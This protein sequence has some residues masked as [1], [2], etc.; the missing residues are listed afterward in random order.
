MLTDVLAVGDSCGAWTNWT[1]KMA[2]STKPAGKDSAKVIISSWRDSKPEHAATER[3][4]FTTADTLTLY[5]F[6]DSRS[7]FFMGDDLTVGWVLG[8]NPAARSTAEVVEEV[9]AEDS[10]PDSKWCRRRECLR[11]SMRL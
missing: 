6:F 2:S 3:S 8:W 9:E 7:F 4:H 10:L 5:C 11:I 1:L